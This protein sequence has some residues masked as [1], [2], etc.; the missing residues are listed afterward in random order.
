MVSNFH[1]NI[2]ARCKAIRRILYWKFQE[3]YFPPSIMDIENPP[4]VQ[5][6]AAF[7]VISRLLSCLVTEAVLRA[8]YVAIE[9]ISPAAGVV[10][11]LTAHITSE[12]TVI[13]SGWALHARDILAIVP[14]HHPPVLKEASSSK[15]G[16]SVALLDPLDMLTDIYELGGS[17]FGQAT[18]CH[19][20]GL[21]S[22]QSNF[23]STGQ[24]TNHN[25][26]LFDTT[27]M[28]TGLFTKFSFLL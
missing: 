24:T 7:A 21:D 8:F 25:I 26:G 12:Q 6:R 23:H 10:I 15:H 16:A 27:C 28:G 9:D 2:D 11:I 3:P 22:G 14:V 17:N 18:V 20:S 1:Q 13:D 19:N 4:S 5:K